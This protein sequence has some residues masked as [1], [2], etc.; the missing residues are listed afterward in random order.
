MSNE[1]S[2]VFFSRKQEKKPLVSGRS[3]RGGRNEISGP[4]PYDRNPHNTGQSECYT[5]RQVDFYKPLTPPEFEA[6]TGRHPNGGE[7]TCD[8]T[9]VGREAT[10]Q[11]NRSF[12]RLFDPERKETCLAQIELQ[13]HR[14]LEYQVV[15]VFPLDLRFGTVTSKRRRFLSWN[16]ES[17]VR[18]LG[19]PIDNLGVDLAPSRI[20]IDVDIFALQLERLCYNCAAF[21]AINRHKAVGPQLGEGQRT[22]IFKVLGSDIQ[23]EQLLG[24]VE[25]SVP[26][27]ARRDAQG[28]VVAPDLAVLAHD[29]MTCHQELATAI[30]FA[31]ER[32]EPDEQRAVGDAFPVIEVARDRQLDLVDAGVVCRRR[33]NGAERIKYGWETDIKPLVRQYRHVVTLSDVV[34]VVDDGRSNICWVFNDLA[35]TAAAILPVDFVGV[36]DELG[37]GKRLKVGTGREPHGTSPFGPLLYHGEKLVR[38]MVMGKLGLV[39]AGNRRRIKQG[40]VESVRR[41]SGIAVAGTEQSLVA[42][43]RVRICFIANDVIGASR[44]FVLR[45]ESDVVVLGAI[46]FYSPREGCCKR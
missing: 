39:L 3:P 32:F 41:Y 22:R 37:F 17:L 30:I 11:R 28:V 36:E 15:C 21:T 1:Y 35:D 34:L 44:P 20:C 29:G 33:R 6:G 2:N 4:Q 18:P 12:R 13:A 46:P 9:R 19:L 42:A 25:L 38:L 31:I 7:R 45:I 27:D 8:G 26:L 23:S 24:A 5:H 16:P 43:V 40:P 14:L 10:L